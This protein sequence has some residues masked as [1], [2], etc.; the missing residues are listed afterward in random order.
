M[1]VVSVLLSFGV[2]FI[3]FWRYTNI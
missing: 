2:C 3:I 1:F